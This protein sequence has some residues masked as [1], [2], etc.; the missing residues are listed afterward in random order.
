MEGGVGAAVDGETLDPRIRWLE[1]IRGYVPKVGSR[2]D[3]MLL[4]KSLFSD[5]A[6]SKVRLLLGRNASFQKSKACPS[7][8]S[9]SLKLF[10]KLNSGL[11]VVCNLHNYPARVTCIEQEILL[12]FGSQTSALRA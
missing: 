5:F 6:S 12:G 9:V 2:R 10:I 8:I 11:T 1:K 7:M 3:E 4:F